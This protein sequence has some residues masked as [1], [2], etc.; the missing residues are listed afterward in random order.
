MMNQR[1]FSKLEFAMEV[2]VLLLNVVGLVFSESATP[3]DI[4]PSGK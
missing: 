4:I 2:L 1:K 3:P